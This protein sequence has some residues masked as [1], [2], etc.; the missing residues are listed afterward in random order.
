MHALQCG[1]SACSWG[2]APDDKQQRSDRERKPRK[3]SQRRTPAAAP[4]PAP[5]A[6]PTAKENKK[7]RGSGGSVSAWKAAAE[8]RKRARELLKL[9]N[10]FLL[11]RWVA[12][13]ISATMADEQETDPIKTAAS[14]PSASHQT[15]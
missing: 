6:E 2:S 3:H 9:V 15:V 11:I 5:R 13:Y 8:A 4:T 14:K 7:P 1:G 10:R 12:L